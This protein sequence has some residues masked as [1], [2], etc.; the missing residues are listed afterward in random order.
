MPKGV[1]TRTNQR[2]SCHYAARLDPDKV[3]LIRRS[4][5]SVYMLAKQ[6]KVSAWTIHNVRSGKTWAHVEPRNG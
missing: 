3:R 4:S 1:F 6:L 5:E 2:G